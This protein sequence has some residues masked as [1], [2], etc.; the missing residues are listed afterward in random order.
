MSRLSCDCVRSVGIATLVAGAFISSAQCLAQSESVGKDSGNAI[1][2]DEPEQVVAPTLVSR[3]TIRE[4]YADGKPRVEREVARYSDNTFQA[5][6]AHREYY[7]NGQLFVEGRFRNGRQDGEWTYWFETGKQNRKVAYKD[8]KLDGS[9]EVTRADGTI[10]A[11]RSF[12][13]GLRDGDWVTYD[14]TGKQPLT[15]EHYVDG[16]QNGTWKVWHPGGQQKL[17]MD[18][19]DG[20]LDGTRTEWDE[21]GEKRMEVTYAEG[22]PN[23]TLTRW[24]PD[25]RKLVQV[26]KE[27]RLESEAVQ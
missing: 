11:K 5:E 20:K 22:K 8:G 17:Q 7:P 1:Y 25:G 23:G 4:Q 12:K 2:L 14:D 13:N 15:E 10:S 21:K 18:F 3:D 16:K 24:F 19:K 6:G 27:G 26:Y 9:W